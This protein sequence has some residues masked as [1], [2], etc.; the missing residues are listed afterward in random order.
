MKIISIFSTLT[1]SLLLGAMLI[2][3]SF[4]SGQDAPELS[5]KKG[6]GAAVFQQGKTAYA[7]QQFKEAYGLFKDA[8][9][10][11]KNR[12]TRTHVELWLA[13]TEGANELTALKKQAADGKE[14]SAYRLAVKNYSKFS[15]TLIGEE[16]KKFLIELQRKLFHVLEDFERVSR[17]YSEKYGKKFVDEAEWVQEGK[18]A[19]KWDVASGK[20]ELKIKGVPGGLSAYKSIVFYLDMPRGGSPYQLV[21]VVPGKSE[22][23]VSQV[24]VVSNAY[25]AQMKSHKGLKRIEVPLRNFK[26]QGDVSWD[27]VKDFRI[28]FLG[29]KKFT[30]YVDFIA[31]LK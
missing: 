10:Q 19:L 2:T 28:Q 1:L 8:R 21:F 22:A 12:D 7:A 25:I 24:K 9:K 20:T 27:R 18:R 13:S 30:A 3:T 26:G 5:W 4:L 11:A 23:G 31:L 17:R 14:S 6:D 16:Y 29:A 15:K